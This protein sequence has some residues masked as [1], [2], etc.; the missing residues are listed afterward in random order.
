MDEIIKYGKIKVLKGDLTKQDV[1]AIV[2]AANSGLRGG[3]G[4]D[5]AIH[6]AAGKVIDDECRLIIEKIGHL[7]TGEAVITTGGNLKA[8]YVIHAVG[9]IWRGGNENEMDL[10]A[11][12]YKNSLKIAEERGIKS[13]AFPNISTGI[14]GFPKDLAAKVAIE[15]VCESLKT[16]K[17]INEIRF[18]CYDEYNY[19]IYKKIIES[20][21]VK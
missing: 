3:G 9:P 18:V 12:A 16:L 2:N 17:S 11:D 14:F 6:R 5:G 1:E 4:V 21:N 20:K 10:L 13:I 15:T 8:R 7:K 19:D